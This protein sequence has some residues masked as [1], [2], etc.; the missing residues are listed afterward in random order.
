MEGLTALYLICMLIMTLF[1]VSILLMPG[2]RLVSK[3]EQFFRCVAMILL[4]PFVLIIGSIVVLLQ[5]D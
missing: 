1:L 2:K 3:P 5:L 4:A